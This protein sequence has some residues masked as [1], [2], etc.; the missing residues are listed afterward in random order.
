MG[1]AAILL[2]EE[3]AAYIPKEESL[4]ARLRHLRPPMSDAEFERRYDPEGYFR[5]QLMQ[6]LGD[7][8]QMLVSL[9][10]SGGLPDGTKQPYIPWQSSNRP[11]SHKPSGPTEL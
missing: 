9:S 1:G 6:V 10:A 8:H 2:S 3:R 4:S 7:I 11:Q 5:T